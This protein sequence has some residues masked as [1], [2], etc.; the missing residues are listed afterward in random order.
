MQEKT[1]VILAVEAVFIIAVIVIAFGA[2]LEKNNYQTANV[3]EFSEKKVFTS[4]PTTEKISL[5]DLPEK[6]LELEK[7]LN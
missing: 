1:R 3:V 6:T 7:K 2:F 5:K 4:E